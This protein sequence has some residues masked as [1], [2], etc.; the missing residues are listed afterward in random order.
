VEAKVMRMAG[1]KEYRKAEI[2]AHTMKWIRCALQYRISVHGRAKNIFLR[3]GG[4]GIGDHRG[5]WDVNWQTAVWLYRASRDSTEC[6]LGGNP[7]TLT[8]DLGASRLSQGER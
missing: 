1:I 2:E 6:D 8:A 5:E 3:C 7:N 4:D